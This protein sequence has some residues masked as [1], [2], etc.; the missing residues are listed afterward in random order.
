M[1]VVEWR[2]AFD[3]LGARQ[4]SARALAARRRRTL[5]SQKRDR[6]FCP[7]RLLRLDRQLSR[8]VRQFAL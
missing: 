2:A 7:R 8:L 6:F 1:R 3:E 5:R 4:R